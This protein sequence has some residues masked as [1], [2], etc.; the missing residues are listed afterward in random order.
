MRGRLKDTSDVSKLILNQN[1]MENENNISIDNKTSIYFK[2]CIVI[3]QNSKVTHDN[4]IILS[5]NKADEPNT[6]EFRDN[7]DI[8]VHGKLIDNDNQIVEGL[9][10]FLE[11]QIKLIN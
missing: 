3:G 2:N 10:E 1:N 9:R 6:L 8:L 4:S 5:S 11:K 7:G